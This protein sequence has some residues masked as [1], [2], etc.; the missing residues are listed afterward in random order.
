MGR[1]NDL[2][3]VREGFL[4]DLLLVDGDPTADISILQ[5]PAHLSMIMTDGKLY[6]LSLQNDR[7]LSKT[8]VTA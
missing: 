7:R 2:G 3:L 5:D 6:K 1:P 8:A 4:A